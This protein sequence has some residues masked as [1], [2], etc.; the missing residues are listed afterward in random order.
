M[1]MV[2]PKNLTTY[3]DVSTEWS[4]ISIVQG[5]K[6]TKDAHIQDEKEYY[7]HTR[8]ESKLFFSAI[9]RCQAWRIPD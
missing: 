2:H 1:S 3:P 4:G 6:K 8:R 9:S 7:I 5:R